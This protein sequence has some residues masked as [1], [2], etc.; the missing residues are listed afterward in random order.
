MCPWNEKYARPVREDAFRPRAAVAGKNARNVARD[1]LAMSDDDFRIAFKGSLMKRAKLR[2][3]KR[4]SAVVLGNM[5]T[6][7]N[8]PS[9]I[10]VLTDAEPLVCVHA[11][12]A[13]ARIGSADALAALR[14]RQGEQD[15]R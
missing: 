3:L 10:A 1:L 15:A 2:G 11:A 13:L 7:E 14:S 12:W 6:P 9:L 5:D 8:A 4:N